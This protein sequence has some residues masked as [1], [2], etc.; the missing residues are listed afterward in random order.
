MKNIFLSIMLILGMSSLSHAQFSIIP[1]AGMTISNANLQQTIYNNRS[2]FSGFTGGLGFNYAPSGESILSF[3]PEL[4]FTQKGFRASYGILEENL[5]VRGRFAYN[6]L[7]LPL[8]VKFTFGTQKLRLYALG[9]PSIGYLTGGNLRARA[10]AF[11]VLGYNFSER[12]SFTENPVTPWE[13]NANRFEFGF[14]V[15]GGIGY[16]IGNSNTMIFLEPR[17][18]AAFT[19]FD[20]DR[21][22]KHNV[23]SIMAGVQLPLR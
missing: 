23:F 4:L 16:M 9:G 11:G 17:F 8:L 7:E 18:N 1:K 13:V 3:Q 20:R 6:Y 15:G 21:V 19:D 22:S 5:N 10:S 14:H 2:S 12:L